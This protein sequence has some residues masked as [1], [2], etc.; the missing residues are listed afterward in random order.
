MSSS[1]IKPV[2]A[3]LWKVLYAALTL[4]NVPFLHSSMNSPRER[5]WGSMISAIEERED[6]SLWAL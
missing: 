3:T 1:S 2:I 4:S 6:H 5:D